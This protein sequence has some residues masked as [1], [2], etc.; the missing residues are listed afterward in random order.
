M[1]AAA[2]AEAPAEPPSQPALPASKVQVQVDQAAGPSGSPT[3]A[4]PV[5]LQAV[6]RC[7]RAG[8]SGGAALLEAVPPEV[9]VRPDAASSGAVLGLQCA[10]EAASFLE[11]A[12]GQVRLV[13]G[14]CAKS[15]SGLTA[16]S[17]AIASSFHR[18]Q[19]LLP[20][21]HSTRPTA[22]LPPLPG[23]GPRQAVLDGALLGRPWRGAAAG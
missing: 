10:S 8:G 2:A 17:H 13:A 21:C 7:L 9:S 16:P 12:V 1:S 6:G 4:L 5:I 11:A 19:N 18:H 3:S 15:G 14:S 22:A 23:A 20:C